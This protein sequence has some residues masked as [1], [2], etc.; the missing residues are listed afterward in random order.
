MKWLA[1]SVRA[2]AINAAQEERNPSVFR[3]ARRTTKKSVVM[4]ESELLQIAISASTAVLTVF[5]VF[6][7]IVSGYIVALY[8]FLSKAPLGLRGLAFLLLSVAFVLL[9]AMA[10]NFQYMG[11][12]IHTAWKHLPS[13]ATGME[14]LG[15]P[16]IV[17]YVFIDSQMLG[18]WAGWF[19]GVVVYGALG[20]MT[21]FYSWKL[22]ERGFD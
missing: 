15:P 19:V 1:L 13:R 5:S 10:W 4:S 8:L 12:G 17:R 3:P 2:A 9:G 22:P 11:E 20:Y 14:S 6:F 7:G 18:I 16:L 21:F